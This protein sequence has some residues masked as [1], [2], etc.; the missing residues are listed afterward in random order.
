MS[1]DVNDHLSKGVETCS[2]GEGTLQ[3]RNSWRSLR[4]WSGA[5]YQSTGAQESL[6][7]TEMADCSDCL[8]KKKKI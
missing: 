1:P 6:R 3:I 2:L 7:V 8:E 5:K 4:W